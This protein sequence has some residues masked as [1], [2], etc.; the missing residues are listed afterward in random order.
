MTAEF[1]KASSSFNKF[2]KVIFG[3]YMGYLFGYEIFND[4]IAG[5][6][7]PYIVLANH[8]NFWDPFLLSMCFTDPVY[9]VTSDTHFRNPLLRQLLKLVGAIPKTKNVSD[10]H[11]IRDIIRVAGSGGIIGIFPEG[12]RNWDGK[13]L[14]LFY[15]T[16]KLIKT[17]KLPVITVL[18]KGA[19]LSMPRWANKTRKGEL[20][21]ICS[22]LLDADDLT[23]LS[24]DEIF[25]KITDGLSHDEY[26]YQKSRMISYKSTFP[27]ERL[28]L[29]LFCCPDCKSIGTMKSRNEDFFCTNCG[30][31]LKY[32]E[33]GFFSSSGQELYFDNPRDWNIWQLKYLESLADSSALSVSSN[34]IFEDDDVLLQTGTVVRLKSLKKEQAGRLAMHRDFMRFEGSQGL[35]L[36]IPLN[37]ISGQNIQMNN[38]LEF[39][40]EK[41]L[42]K[43]TGNTFN[44]S[45]YKWV[46]AI[47]LFKDPAKR[48]VL[49]QN[50]YND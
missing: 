50:I 15:P 30:Y 9:F 16:A 18:F 27:A 41:T 31:T 20:H 42:Y 1:K 6:E 25:A 7:P 12:R 4:Q 17:L 22:K 8:T 33:F 35:L 10:P 43:F 45:A 38:Q 34:V 14:P 40:H 29:F 24:T 39:Y 11:A 44:L 2:L 13:T 23:A 21:M 28:E 49:E 19:Y 37:K 46:K 36:D 47:E 5:L 26:D 32:N 3:S 48:M